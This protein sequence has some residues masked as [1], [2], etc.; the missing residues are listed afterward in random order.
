MVSSDG[1]AGRCASLLIR[2]G[3]AAYREM[4]VAPRLSARP[5]LIVVGAGALLYLLW[6]VADGLLLIFSGLLLAAFLD[7]C[8]W[9]LGKV[10]P[11]PRKAVLALVV[12]LVFLAAA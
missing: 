3:S 6:S 11:L 4:V 12:L 1:T 10:L 2:E 5:L 8:T 9:L 7:E